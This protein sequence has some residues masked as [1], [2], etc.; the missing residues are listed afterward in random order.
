MIIVPRTRGSAWD[1]SARPL[2]GEV[3][4]RVVGKVGIDATVKPRYDIKDFERAWPVG[5]NEVKL[6]DYLE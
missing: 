6:S 5:W 4:N 3:M 2:P 1:P